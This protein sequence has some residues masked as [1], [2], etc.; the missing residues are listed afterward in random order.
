MFNTYFKHMSLHKYTRVAKGQDGVKVKSMI[1]LMLVKKDMLHYVQDVWAVRRLGQGLSDH[2]VIVCKV[3]LVGA[4][5]KSR[6]VV[7][8]ARRIISETLR[9]DRYREEYTRSLK[10]KRVGRDR[11]NNVK[12]MWEEVKWAMVETT[13]EECGSVRVGERTQ[14]VCGGTMR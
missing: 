13:R 9:E 10:G 6:E 14:R 11:D 5:I 4:W 7:I 2:H 12:H 1:D 8:G 3:K